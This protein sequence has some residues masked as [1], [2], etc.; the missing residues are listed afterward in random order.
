MYTSLVN[1]QIIISLLKQNNIMHLV[2]SPGTR[3]VP[4]VHSVETDP[5]FTCYSIVD[6]RSAGYFALGLS[7]ALDEPVCISCTS[8]TATCNYLPAMKE[9]QKNH[10]Q[11]I[12]LTADRDMRFLYQME[13]QM[14]NQENMYKRY[15]KCSINLPVIRDDDDIWFCVRNVN[16]ALLELNHYEKGPIQ[17]NYQVAAI[18]NFLV[19][20]LP[21]F[22]KMDR[23]EEE[24]VPIVRNE[25]QEK[26]A[27]K[28]RILVLCGEHYDRSDE[29]KELLKNFLQKY[30]AVISYDCFSNVTSDSFLKTVLVTEAMDNDE[31]EGFL[32]DLVI[33]VGIHIWSTIK[34]KLKDYGKKIEHWHIA[35]DGQVVDGLKAL[36][37]IFECTP[38]LFFKSMNQGRVSQND[39][40]YYCLWKKRI[41]LVRYPKL[42]FTNFSIIR[43]FAM[44]IPEDSLL[45]LSILNSVRLINFCALKSQVRCFANL[46]ADGIDGTL[47]TFLGQSNMEDELSFLIIGDLS[48]LYDLNASLMQLKRNQRILVINNFA[49]GE[50][51]TNF[52]LD[53]FTT[54]NKHIAAGHHT[55]ISEGIS[56]MNATYLSASNQLELNENLKIFVSDSQEAIIMEV[57]TDADTDS[58]VL[59]QFYRMNKKNTV[60]TF[61]KKG[62]RKVFKR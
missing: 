7:E 19:K 15:T 24:N 50:F 21:V 20:E 23:I 45:H 8:S 38:A 17:I 12:A 14:I 28:K 6:E 22:R 40:K 11:L 58:K 34:Y 27:S 48:F 4:F 49:G 5:F 36:T 26:L 53:C 10:I 59:K 16:K 2:L 39:N 13:D 9:A 51:Y 56:M 57:F 42:R 61:V 55:K 44:Q 46:G 32:P 1:V 3:N 30:N 52:G 47:S 43:D 62:V 60:K 35:K 18:G 29:L 41:N 33:T 25:Y 37:S 54:L 31:F